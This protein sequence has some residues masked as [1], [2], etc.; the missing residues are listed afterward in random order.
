MICFAPPRWMLDATATLSPHPMLIMFHNFFAGHRRFFFGLLRGDCLRARIRF[1]TDRAPE[2][3]SCWSV[4]TSV[5]AAALPMAGLER[6]L[7]S[8]ANPQCT[9]R[10][11]STATLW[12][13]P[14][15][16]SGQTVCPTLEPACEPIQS[17]LDGT[18]CYPRG[19]GRGRTSGIGL[20]RQPPQSSLLPMPR[21]ARAISS[22]GLSFVRSAVAL[23]DPLSQG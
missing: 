6:P 11:E 14:V 13:D 23:P 17:H 19:L 9:H 8:L 1:R 12:G 21:L 20:G 4:A 18:A 2:P 15:A 3:E 16:G 5:V 7:G 10:V 22:F